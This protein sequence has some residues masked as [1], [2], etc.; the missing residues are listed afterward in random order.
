[1]HE[2]HNGPS[3]LRQSATNSKLVLIKRILLSSLSLFL[4]LFSHF[5]LFKTLQ[6]FVSAVRHTNKGEI[7]DN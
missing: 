2:E 7:T 5:C 1:M 3:A 6:V 4:S